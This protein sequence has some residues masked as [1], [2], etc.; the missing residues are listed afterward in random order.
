MPDW[1]CP[2][3]ITVFT[4]NHVLSFVLA[5]L[6]IA[7]V[8]FY[9]DSK[10]LLCRWLEFWKFH[11]RLPSETGPLR[12]SLPSVTLTFGLHSSMPVTLSPSSSHRPSYSIPH[13]HMQTCIM[14]PSAA[15][16]SSDDVPKTEKGSIKYFTINIKPLRVASS[17][18][19]VSRTKVA[20]SIES[21]SS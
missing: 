13:P 1:V 10:S 14:C 9:T 8:V 15:I 20:V 17:S 6:R 7:S 21:W 5:A 16:A 3:I 4:D 19:K 11:S 18:V 12:S 2:V